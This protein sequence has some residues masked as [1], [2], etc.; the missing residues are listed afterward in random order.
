[1]RQGEERRER[2]RKIHLD[3]KTKIAAFQQQHIDDGDDHHLA[4]L[5]ESI[6]NGRVLF[7]KAMREAKPQ[8]RAFR[9]LKE[10][11]REKQKNTM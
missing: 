4:K 1:M 9:I 2:E 5:V 10:M 3:E 7:A 8:H 11:K 6:L